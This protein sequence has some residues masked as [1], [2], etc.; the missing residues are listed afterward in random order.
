MAFG[1]N[2]FALARRALPAAGLK[3]VVSLGASFASLQDLTRL[4]ELGLLLFDQSHPWQPSKRCRHIFISTA[5]VRGRAR[6]RGSASRASRMRGGAVLRWNIRGRGSAPHGAELPTAGA[7]AELPALRVQAN[8]S[9]TTLAGSTPV[10]RWSSPWNLKLKRSCSMP[11]ACS[12]V[13]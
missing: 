3:P 13:A 7:G 9:F 12:K 1:E 5:T 11:R 4:R 6:H 8:N 10:R 2:G